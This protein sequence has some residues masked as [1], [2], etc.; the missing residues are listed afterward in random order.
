MEEQLQPRE[1]WQPIYTLVLVA[2]AIYI[3]LFYFITNS[4]S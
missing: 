4:F 3:V 1:K 2:N